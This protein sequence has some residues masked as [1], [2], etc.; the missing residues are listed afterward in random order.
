MAKLRVHELAKE[1][2]IT[3]KELLTHLRENGEFV[4]AS[5]S[6][7]EP[8]VVR[9]VREHYAAA[10]PKKAES[11]QKRKP[12]PAAGAR[13]AAAQQ[14]RPGLGPVQEV[15]QPPAPALRAGLV[16]ELGQTRVEHAHLSHAAGE[17]EVVG[18][19]QAL[20]GGQSSQG[21]GCEQAR[22]GPLDVGV[23][24]RDEVPARR[25]RHPRRELAHLDGCIRHSCRCL[26]ALGD[27]PVPGVPHT[28]QRLQ[29]CRGVRGDPV[30]HLLTGLTRGGL[31]RQGRRP[32]PGRRLR[33]GGHVTQC[34]HTREF[35]Q[36]TGG[37]LEAEAA[38]GQGHGR[39]HR[40]QAGKG[41]PRTSGRPCGGEGTRGHAAVGVGGGLRD[42]HRI[43]PRGCGYDG[44]HCRVVQMKEPLWPPPVNPHHCGPCSRARS[45]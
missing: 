29:A 22:V 5:G 11:A 35:G 33:A 6:T 4:K 32:G 24:G 2:G 20:R 27:R 16:Q 43:I 44:S 41:R 42:H 8:P 18:V 45:P 7:L 36:R 3:S 23:G 37:G 10:A 14:V 9:T 17:I 31:G 38:P 19:G 1:L 21:G 39:A 13:P 12:S 30:Q 28:S 25:Q 26:C 34:G 40:D 15:L